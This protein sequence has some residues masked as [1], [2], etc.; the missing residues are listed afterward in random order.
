MQPAKN[1]EITFAIPFYS[2]IRYLDAC[3]QSVLAQS[4]SNWEIVISDDC[5]PGNEIQSLLGRYSDPRIRYS[6]NSTNLGM[7]GNW[8]RCLELAET[9][10]VTILHDD[11][12]LL[13]D[14]AEQL[15]SA[16][17]FHPEAAAIFCNARIID[18]AGQPVFSFPDY[19]KKFLIPNSSGVELEG[20]FGVS[21]LLKGNFIMCPTLCYRK[22]RLGARRFDSSW[23]MVLDLDFTIGVLMDG[24]KLVG[25]REI[26]Y[27]YR[28]HAE[29]ATARYT[30]DLSR[31]KEEIRLYDQIGVWAQSRNWEGAARV[32]HWK[33]MIL[34]HLAFR[35][36]Q[37]LARLRLPAVGKKSR[38]LLQTAWSI[39]RH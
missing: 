37:D 34:L 20:E 9:D 4:N 23:K 5:G 30:E 19:I 11:D 13:P 10:L 17:K 15:I 32:A 22:S 8:N 6:R 12:L 3:L 35:I 14:Y 31:F 26:A 27:A 39:V 16:A 18:E 38:F 21:A 25:I 28:R 2:G 24:G 36:V 1:P 33:K 29:N 7:A